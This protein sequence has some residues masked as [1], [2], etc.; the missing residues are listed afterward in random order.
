MYAANPVFIPPNHM[1]EAAIR[2]AKDE[3]NF[4]PFQKLVEKVNQP[5]GYNSSDQRYATPH[6]PG[7][8]CTNFCG[9]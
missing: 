4:E 7:R 1:V 6:D 9:T 5:W 8:W 3:E 2:A